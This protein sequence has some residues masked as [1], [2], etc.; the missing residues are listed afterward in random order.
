MDGAAV[1]YGL[2]AA[3]ENPHLFDVGRLSFLPQPTMPEGFV[4]ATT[5]TLPVENWYEYASPLFN[6][7]ILQPVADQISRSLSIASDNQSFV[8]GTDTTISRFSSTGQLLW[9]IWP[10]GPAY[11]VNL[12]ANDSIIVAAIGD[13]TIRWYRASDGVELLAFLLMYPTT[14]GS[15]G[16]PE[17]TTPL[18]P[19][20]RI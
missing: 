11:G 17:V 3:L 16:R 13:G 7:T 9:Q 5:N 20:A 18:H 15:P 2:G 19:A 1:W 12:T 6:K 10:E 4:S 14:N 8:I